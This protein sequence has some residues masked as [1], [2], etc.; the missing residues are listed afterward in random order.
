MD[1]IHRPHCT[2]EGGD[3]WSYTDEQWSEVGQKG[4]VADAAFDGLVAEFE[5]ASKRL[6]EVVD[7][8]IDRLRDRV[9]ATDDSRTQK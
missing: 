4:E 8:E 3:D 7:Q 1:D 6:R 2:D 5:S 9:K